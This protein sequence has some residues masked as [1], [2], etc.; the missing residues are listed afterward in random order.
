MS[1]LVLVSNIEKLDKLKASI[2]EFFREEKYEEITQAIGMYSIM[3]DPQNTMTDQKSLYQMVL[4]MIKDRISKNKGKD[5][6]T[7]YVLFPQLMNKILTSKEIVA[8][9]ATL[10]VLTS[11][12]NAFG[13]F[14]SVEN[15][16]FW[17]L[18]DRRLTLEQIVKHIERTTEMR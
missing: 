4:N 1:S 16:F 3:I 17:A 11:H 5:F 14:K 9:A 8:D 6:G 18:E 12:C 10:D 15:F 2:E 7:W 13:Q